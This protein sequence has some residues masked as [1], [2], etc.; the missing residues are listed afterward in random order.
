M[1]TNEK[2]IEELEECH[3]SNFEYNRISFFLRE[4]VAKIQTAVFGAIENIVRI[5]LE[6]GRTRMIVKVGDPEK[7]EKI[8]KD[9][10]LFC[11][12]NH[13]DEDHIEDL[14]LSKF[15]SIIDEETEYRDGFPSSSIH[16]LLEFGAMYTTC[17]GRTI[18]LRRG[19]LLVDFGERGSECFRRYILSFL[20]E[21]T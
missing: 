14:P 11:R 7:M 4:A 5:D 3:E 8:F 6:N 10:V 12:L 15:V 20:S 19:I 16:S 13:D 1:T 17:S 9:I 2:L 21:I 18:I